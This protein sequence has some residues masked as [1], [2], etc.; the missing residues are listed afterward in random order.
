MQIFSRSANKLPLVLGVGGLLG[1]ASAVTAVWYYFSP[2]FTQVG[3]SPTQPVAY[4]HRLHARELG[5]DCR[6]CHSNVERSSM[7]MVPAT[8]TCV[9]CHQLVKMDSP[10]LAMIRESWESGK[11]MEWV[12]VHKLADYAYFDHSVH[13]NV[14]VGCSTC[15]GRVDEADQVR[16]SETLSMGWCL[17]CHRDVRANQGAS[18]FIRPVSQMTNMDWKPIPNHPV[19]LPRRLDPPENCTAC[20]R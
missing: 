16:Q 20:H 5:I 14:G 8:Q 11:R 4:S 3:Y 2:S 9:N 13:V 1:L 19:D 7:A 15:H 17:E 18:R 12:R 6:Y 10:K